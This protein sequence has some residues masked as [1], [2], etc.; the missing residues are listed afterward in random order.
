MIDKQRLVDWLLELT[1]EPMITKEMAIALSVVYGQV[2]AGV[3]DY[4]EEHTDQSTEEFVK[5]VR[6]KDCKFY[7]PLDSNRPY[8]CLYVEDVFGDDYCSRGKKR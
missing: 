6:C 3:F 7:Y 5:V 8:D 4:K 2:M 1:E